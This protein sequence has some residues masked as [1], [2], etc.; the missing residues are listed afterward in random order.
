MR[1]AERKMEQVEGELRR[2]TA[3]ME[4]EIAI[5]KREKIK[6]VAAARSLEDLKKIEQ[7]RGYKPGWAKN[8]FNS[9]QRAA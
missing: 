4:S 8:V 3:E 7:E 9:R 6:Q 5:K 1:P 2:V